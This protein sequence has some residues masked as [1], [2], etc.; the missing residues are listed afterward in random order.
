MEAVRSLGCV[1]IPKLLWGKAD[2]K[3]LGLS[4]VKGRGHRGG[5]RPGPHFPRPGKPRA[6]YLLS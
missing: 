5:E 1:K 3:V 6:G 2:W 4:D